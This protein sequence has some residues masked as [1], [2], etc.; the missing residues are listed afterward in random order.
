MRSAV[1]AACPF[2]RFVLLLDFLPDLLD[3]FP[4]PVA[5][6]AGPPPVAGL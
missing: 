3:F 1:G 6:L 2:T 4:V 5:I